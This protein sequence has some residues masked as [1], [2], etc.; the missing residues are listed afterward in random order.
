MC[1]QLH[2]QGFAD[3]RAWLRLGRFRPPIALVPFPAAGE[4]WPMS[5]VNQ[6]DG[7]MITFREGRQGKDFKQNGVGIAT[8]AVLVSSANGLNQ[9]GSSGLFHGCWALRLRLACFE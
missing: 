5:V 6:I 1:S 7:P 4:P 3:P 2:Q 8:D 9:K